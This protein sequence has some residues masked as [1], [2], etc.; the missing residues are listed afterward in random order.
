MQQTDTRLRVDSTQPSALP[1]KVIYIL[2]RARTSPQIVCWAFLL[3]VFTVPFETIDLEAISG[4]SSLSRLAGLLFFITCFLYPKVC[5]RRPQQAL[6][7]FAGYFSVYALS[8]LSIPEQ[9]V[10]K[11]I[12]EIQTCVQLL[13]LCWVGS[14]LLQEEKFARH[15]LLT[16][17]IATLLVAIGLLLGLPGFSQTR[18]G[19]LSV[20]GSDPNICAIIVA[21]GAQA[22]IGFGIDQIRRNIWM[23]V[24]FMAIS[25]FPLTA[26]VYTGSRGGI[27]AFLAGVAVYALP[28]RSSKRKMTAILGVAIAVIGVV[29][30]VVNDQNTLSRLESSYNTGDTAGR[31]KLIA[32]SREMISEKPLLGWGPI[33]WTYELGAREGQGYKYRSAHNIFLDMLMAGGLLG[34]MPCLIGLGL[35]ARA[36][37]TARVCNLGPLP[38]VWLITMILASMSGPWLETKSMW[39]V[40]TLSLASGASIV[41]QY[42]RENLMIRTILQDIHKR[43]TSHR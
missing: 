6:W 10:G 40:L 34:A 35:C 3:F 12:A 11:L 16:F 33:V 19:R 21:L 37:W 41:E 13:V 30:S 5:F 29:Y 24:T 43:N 28:Y 2:G 20:A 25:L 8:G 38:L 23:R 36:A 18:E 7:W 39:L 9:F 1:K 17:S 15:L 22:L 42:K 26:I 31:D 4:A 27:I 14:T 32:A